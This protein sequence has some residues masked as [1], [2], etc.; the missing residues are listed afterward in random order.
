MSNFISCITLVVTTLCAE[1]LN[2]GLK[3]VLLAKQCLKCLTWI[4]TTQNDVNRY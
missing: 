2:N 4:S 3:I 1:M